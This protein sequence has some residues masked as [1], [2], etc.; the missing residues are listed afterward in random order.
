MEGR[1][2]K[3][4][5][6][7]DNTSRDDVLAQFIKTANYNIKCHGIPASEEEFELFVGLTQDQIFHSNFD[8]SVFTD[9][10]WVAI[11]RDIIAKAK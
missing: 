4:Y 5:S 6:I 8:P 1:E 3:D 2:A 10:E 9:E 7:E 11:A